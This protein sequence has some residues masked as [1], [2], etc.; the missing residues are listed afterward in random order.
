MTNPFT[1][2][3]VGSQASGESLVWLGRTGYLAK[4]LVYC[5]VGLLSLQAALQ[6]SNQAEG[7][8][9]AIRA[10]GQQPFG[11]VLLALTAL[12]LLAYAVWR[13]IMA[14]FDT[15]DQGRDA[16]GIVKRLGY[17]ASGS[18]NLLLALLAAQALLGAGGGGG[19]AKQEWTA[20]ILAQP[21]GAW[22]V[23]LAGA[24]FVGVGLYQFFRAY[25][26]SFMD[27]YRTA[28]MSATQRTWARRLGRL[29]L[30]ARGVTFSMIGVFIIQAALQAD[31]SETEGLG[32]ALQT[33]AQQP[34][35]PWL[36]GVVAAGFVAYG[37]FC[38]SYTRWRDFKHA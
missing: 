7:S 18:A 33:L 4:G 30:A 3:A 37:L 31:P 1:T 20:R 28:G 27:R 6:S 21:L 9:G 15:R 11:Q 23:G 34:Y 38:F 8:E 17:L 2:A 22:L 29:G 12:G 10:I 19:D 36:L 25:K 26:A 5:V 24:I 32:G 13:F 14:A 16:E 35:G